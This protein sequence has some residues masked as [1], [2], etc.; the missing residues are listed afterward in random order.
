MHTYKWDTVS[1]ERLDDNVVRRMIVGAKE[2]LV[3]WEFKKGARAARHHHPHEQVVMMVS[4]KLRLAVG[5]EE[6]IMGPDDIVVIP[7]E[8]PHEAEALEDTVVIDIF[9]P[10]REDFLSGAGPAYLKQ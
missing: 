5:D 6:T 8:V 4:G 7:S 3:R 9:S 1:A 2:M 10:P